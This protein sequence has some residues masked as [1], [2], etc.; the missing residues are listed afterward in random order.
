MRKLCSVIL[1]G[2]LAFSLVSGQAKMGGTSKMS[3]TSRTGAAGGGFTPLALRFD[4]NA[5]NALRISSGTFD[6]NANYTCMGWGRITTDTNAVATIL[7]VGN[8]SSVNID[9]LQTTVDGTSLRVSA[10]I[11]GT[12]T[13]GTT[14]SLTVGTWFHWAMVRSGTAMLTLWVD[15]NSGG[16][17]ANDITGRSAQTDINLGRTHCCSDLTTEPWNGRLAAAKCW[18]SALNEAQIEAEMNNYDAQLASPWGEWYLMADGADSS[19]N[20]RNFTVVGSLTV[21]AGPPISQ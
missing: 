15:G 5:A 9:I 21:E 6:Y 2:L 12:C 8:Q 20:G 10:C 16:S 19:G 14:T 11:S 3:G 7:T 17:S 4:G 18:T 13:D 1:G